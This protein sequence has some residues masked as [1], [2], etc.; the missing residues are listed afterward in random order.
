MFDTKFFPGAKKFWHM[1]SMYD[2]NSKHVHVM[3]HA[4]HY[5]SS[6]FEG[7]RA[8]DT[9]RGPAVFRLDDHLNRFFIS[10]KVMHMKVP[11]PKDK[12]VEVINQVMRENMLRAAY[13]RPNLF[14]GYGNLGLV[15]K[16]CPVEL[17]VACWAWG[18][19]LGE[20]AIENG[21]HTLLLSHRRVHISQIDMR[22]KVGGIYAQSNIEGTL[23]RSLGFDEGIFL[24]LE[25][26]IAEGP[27]EN[28]FLVKE[29]KVKTN[30]EKESILQGI[31]RT[32]VLTLAK[33]L[34]YEV[35]IGPI[36]VEEFLS[37][38]EAFFT[39]TA[40]EVTPICRVTNGS[41]PEKERS[42]WKEFKIGNGKP[43]LITKEL[44]QKYADVVRGKDPKYEEWLTYIYKSAEEAKSYLEA[45]E[46]ESVNK[47]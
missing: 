20:K 36:E 7:I 41:D 22:A 24:N 14:Y 12:I 6:V 40:A 28:I 3:S 47:F 42:Q 10:A 31:T 32:T 2:W 23:A 29:R 15:P 34:G 44:A 19:Y 1:G 26:R 25:G 33:D 38:D 17:T 37:S 35:E 11:Y 46:I 45:A 5:G 43:G 27:G 13:I 30:D 16:A 8:Y 9:N 39:G 4:L 21:V 18:T